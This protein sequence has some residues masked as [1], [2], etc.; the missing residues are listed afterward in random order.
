MIEIFKHFRIYDNA[1]LSSSFMHN[2]RPSRKHGYQLYQKRS[3]DGERGLQTNSFYFRVTKQ[4]NELPVQ[5]VEAPSINTFKNRLDAAWVNHPLKYN[6]N[7]EIQS[8]L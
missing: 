5:V 3:H 4:W 8:D 7:Q 6:H 1:I 2:N